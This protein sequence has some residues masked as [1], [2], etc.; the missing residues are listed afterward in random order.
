MP[1]A[2]VA[3][4]TTGARAE[5]L[6]FKSTT[7]GVL[8]PTELVAITEKLN[9]PAAEGFPVIRPLDWLMV[10]PDGKSAAL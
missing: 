5:G 3:L 9:K 7:C 1:V 6:I 10:K 4:V 2:V 8:E